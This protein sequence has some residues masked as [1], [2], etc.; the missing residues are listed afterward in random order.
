MFPVLPLQVETLDIV[1][2][3]DTI[4]TQLV[5]KPIIAIK[6]FHPSF[7]HATVEPN[8]EEPERVLLA[9]NFVT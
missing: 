7:M 1:D 6:D 3:Y 2:A 4:S 9:E 8:L 5:V